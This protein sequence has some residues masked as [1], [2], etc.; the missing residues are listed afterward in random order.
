METCRQCGELA[1][2]F[3][4]GVCLECRDENQAKLDEFNVRKILWDHLTD[5]EKD[6]ILR[7]IIRNNSH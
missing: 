3:A 7:D 4:E 5:Q 6:C 1:E 2:T